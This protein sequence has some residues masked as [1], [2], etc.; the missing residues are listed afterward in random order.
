MV[1]LVSD[2]KRSETFPARVLD[3]SEGGMQLETRDPV[4][5]VGSEILVQFALG[6]RINVHAKIRQADAIEVQLDENA[7]GGE[8]VVRWSD[9]K[10]GRFGVEF[11]ELQ[12]EV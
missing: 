7:D 5:V 1:E 9:G 3:I 8:S 2:N 4:A 11:V 10:S 12:P 6:D